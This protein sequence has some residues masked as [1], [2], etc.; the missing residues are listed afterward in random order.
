MLRQI[1]GIWEISSSPY[2][3]QGNGQIGQTIRFLKGLLS[4]FFEKCARV[5][6]NCSPLSIGLQ[7]GNAC[8]CRIH[9]ISTGKRRGDAIIRW[10]HKPSS[11]SGA[12]TIDEIRVEFKVKES[13]GR[14]S[15]HING[16][17]IFWQY[18]VLRPMGNRDAFANWTTGLSIKSGTTHW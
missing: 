5:Q 14:I 4:M 3:P 1:C 9:T 6:P 16:W 13:A 2:H 7:R 12:T 17:S 15:W 18:K 10:P 8:I 11:N